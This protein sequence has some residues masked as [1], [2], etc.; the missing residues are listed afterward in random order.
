MIF[1]PIIKH[2]RLVSS[3]LS[4]LT[5][6]IKLLTKPGKMCKSILITLYQQMGKFATCLA[7]R[8]LRE[9]QTSTD[10]SSL[11]LQGVNHQI[12]QSPSKFV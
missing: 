1:E 9:L 6:K 5:K 3:S 11:S 10:Q 7:L 4:L 2:H 12:L 8:I